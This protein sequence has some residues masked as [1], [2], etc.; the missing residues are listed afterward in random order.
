[1]KLWIAAIVASLLL[2][3]SGLVHGLWTDRW[4]AP[5]DITGAAE[6]LHKL[7]ME[8]GPWKGKMGKVTPPGAGVAGCVYRDYEHRQT[9]A[10]VSLFIVCGRPGPVSIHTPEACY[11]ASGFTV[12]GR[13]RI[14]V[15]GHGRFWR[16][17]A[18]KTTATDEF[19]QRI[20]YGWHGSAGWAA[21]D[22]PRTAFPTERILHKLYVVRE[23]NGAAAN[24]RGEPCEE[25]LRAALPELDRAVF[26]HEG[27]ATAAR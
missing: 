26:V 2:A 5:P 17:D 6:A 7:P 27:D 24:V 21:P 9:G 14:E 12:G 4:G 23:L 20:V 16:S 8:I 22:D 3:A 25:F 11:G 1:M 18:T 10:V 15:A 13:Q 19:R